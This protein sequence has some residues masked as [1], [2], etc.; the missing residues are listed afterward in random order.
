MLSEEV[1]P[2]KKE[3]ATGY[4][5]QRSGLADYFPTHV[6]SPAFWEA[7]GRAVGAFGFLEET[8]LKAIFAVT[9]TT[10]YKDSEIV[11]AY[12]AWVPK[13]TRSLSDPLGGL[14]DT[15]GKAVRDHPGLDIE[16][17]DSLLDDLR[18][19]CR[20]RNAICHGSWGAPNSG[21]LSVPFFVNKQGEVF[22]TPIGVDFLAQL[23]KATAELACS[24]IDTVTHMGWQFPGSNGPGRVVWQSAADTGAVST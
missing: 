4:V 20:T 7:L 23:R 16:N 22:D 15:Y 19:A 1:S 14:I 9:A 3:K 11:A 18:E 13:L 10:P 8:L 17:F 12:E 21:G 6:H 24:V 5:V 2:L